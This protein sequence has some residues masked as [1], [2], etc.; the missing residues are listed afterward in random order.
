VFRRLS[1]VDT[2]GGR[3]PI[4]NEDGTIVVAINGEIYNHKDL[5]R[6]LRRE[7]TFRT[8]SD[9]EIVVHLYEERGIEALSSLFG[10]FAIAL[11][12]SNTRRLFLARDRLGIKPL[13]YSQ[14][15]SSLLFG[16]EVKALL[17]HPPV[18]AS[19][20]GATGGRMC[21]GIRRSSPVSRRCRPATT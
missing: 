4:A 17:A 11:W 13:Y 9:C 5:R 10:M 12:D 3:Q 14:Q 1:I 18:R 15:G 16:S 8:E 6:T 2:E 21:T 19:S 7:H 20:T